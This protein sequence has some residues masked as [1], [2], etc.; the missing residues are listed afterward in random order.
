MSHERYGAH[1]TYRSTV[2]GS[3]ARALV[4]VEMGQRL[5]AGPLDEFLTARWGLHVQRAGPT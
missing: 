2:K 5:V 1:H 4:G 3:G